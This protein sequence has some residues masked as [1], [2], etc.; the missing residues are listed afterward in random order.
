M[1]SLVPV[2]LL[3]LVTVAYGGNFFFNTTIG[4]YGVCG[5]DH[6][7]VERVLSECYSRC[8]R[9]LQPDGG[10]TLTVHQ[11]DVRNAGPLVV[12]CRKVTLEQI[13]T[14][15]WLF[16]T[17]R[18]EPRTSYK[19]VSEGECRDVV[20]KNCLSYD[21][22]I[23][24]PHELEEEYH[25][26]SDTTSRKTFITAISMPSSLTTDGSKIMILPIG[27]EAKFDI[28]SERG[29]SGHAVYMW[30]DRSYSDE[31]PFSPA[32]KYGCNYYT[33]VA[34]DK[35]YLCAKGGFSVTLGWSL[36]TAYP[37]C[38]NLYISREDLI[39]EVEKGDNM[40]L[41]SQRL[42][43]TDVQYKQ[44][45]T[46]SFRNKMNHVLSNLDSDMCMMQCEMLSLEARIRR[47]SPRLL[48]IGRSLILLEAN[49]TGI[50]CSTAYGC[51]LSKPH[52]FCGSP[53]RIGIE[54]TGQSGYWDPTTP[55][56]ISGDTCS[57][58]RQNETLIMTAGHHSYNVDEDMTVLVPSGF[59]H[60][61][62]LD[63][64]SREHMDG[65][66]FT[67][68]DV[69]NLRSSWI[70]AKGS[71]SGLP[72]EV[73][74]DR[75]ITSPGVSSKLWEFPGVV[76]HYLS[77]KT[78]EVLVFLVVLTLLLVSVGAGFKF[79]LSPLFTSGNPR[80]SRVRRE[81][82]QEYQPVATWI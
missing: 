35:H 38:K 63:L 13:F 58:P 21:C 11:S 71:S 60:G 28:K 50:G 40:Q 69:S 47:D 81:T 30:K 34:S 20:K 49:G 42:D 37:A 66:Q 44:E 43:M 18:T 48:K 82:T 8:I 75:N 55:Y 4:L 62:Q 24:E 2:I 67:R 26:A 57:K 10:Y 1:M 78:H 31:C 70:S 68:E 3:C 65:L 41:H 59:M 80:P 53:P 16:S 15:I 22:N 45:D 54:C 6:L 33:N 12:E 77:Q 7:N 61:K 17:S 73:S 14:K 29:T 51:R 46:E 23:R 72:F 27:S 32:A 56:L 76:A 25:Y 9:L 5:A 74:S 36:E 64:F 39:Y 52:V 19:P 79:V